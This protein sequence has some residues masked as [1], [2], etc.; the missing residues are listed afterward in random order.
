MKCFA[1]QP[2]HAG[3]DLYSYT[4]SRCPVP[5]ISHQVSTLRN[6]FSIQRN[7]NLGALLSVIGYRPLGQNNYC[8]LVQCTIEPYGNRLQGES[9]VWEKKYCHFRHSICHKDENTCILEANSHPSRCQISLSSDLFI[10]TYDFNLH[11]RPWQLSCTFTGGI[12]HARC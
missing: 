8:P 2:R 1:D 3:S 6:A 10:A 9:A 11:C 5:S 7:S 4:P 12:C